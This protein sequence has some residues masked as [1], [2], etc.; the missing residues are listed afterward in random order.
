VPAIL[1][2]FSVLLLAC[3][4]WRPAGRL[5]T[6]LAAVLVVCDMGLYA[7]SFNAT[8]S[9]AIY[10]YTPGA[11]AAIGGSGELFRKATVL[12]DSNDLPP[13]F[14]Q[15][16]L[17]LSWGMVYGVEDVN[18]FNSLQPRRYTDYV[19]GA[20]QNDVSYG[21]LRD[22][23]LLRSD[24][25]ILSSLNVRYVLLPRDVRMPLGPHLQ[26][27]FANV[28]VQVYE[29]TQAYP[30]A[31]FPDRVRTELDPRAVL[32]EVTAAGF[33]GRREALVESEGLPALAP[34]GVKAWCK[35]TRSSPNEVRVRTLTAEPR[36]LVVSEMYMPGWRA[37]VDGVAPPTYRADYL[38]RAVALEPGHH[39]IVF[40][41]V[42]TRFYL[43]CLIGASGILAGAALYLFARGARARIASAHAPPGG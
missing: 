42:P 33:D 14:A 36:L 31:Y 19:F 27:V 16:T 9:P 10:R 32:R 17:A 22:P 6:S 11:L 29:N 25:P 40:R 7:V 26:L 2:G 1:V 13:R 5:T 4:S 34:P 35:A 41:F 15:D 12:V 8:A 21:Y 39:R 37:E 30:R 28:N 24:S 20:Q 23:A 43:G 3:W 18:G 38:F